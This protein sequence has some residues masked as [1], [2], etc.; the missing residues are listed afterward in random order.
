M[1]MLVVH[2]RNMDT[3]E[4]HGIDMYDMYDMYDMDDMDVHI[5]RDRGRA[6]GS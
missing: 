6:R 5:H 2:T 4:T 1:R 3:L